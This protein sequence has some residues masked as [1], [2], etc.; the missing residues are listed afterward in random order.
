MCRCFEKLGLAAQQ[1]LVWRQRHHLKG[2]YNH[3]SNGRN[4]NEGRHVS[5]SNKKVQNLGIRET[6]KDRQRG[7][8][9]EGVRGR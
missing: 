1:R 5:W 8:Q 6:S 3:P 7:F 4:R 2:Y 9:T